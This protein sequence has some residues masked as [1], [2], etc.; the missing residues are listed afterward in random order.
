MSSPNL[1]LGP[2]K[3]ISVNKVPDRAKRLIGNLV[4][5]VKDQYTILHCANAESKTSLSHI[6]H[7]DVFRSHAKHGKLTVNSDRERLAPCDE[8]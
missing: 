2:Y 3:L 6:V 5:D 1:P 7:P 8:V 4:E